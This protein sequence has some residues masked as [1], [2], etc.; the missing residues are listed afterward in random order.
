MKC[1]WSKPFV[2]ICIKKL[3]LINLGILSVLV[4]REYIPRLI[5]LKLSFEGAGRI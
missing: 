1:D 4:K 3:K 2:Y 5:V